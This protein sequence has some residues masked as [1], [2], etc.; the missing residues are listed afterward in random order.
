MGR[1]DGF[2]KILAEAGTDRVLGAHIVGQAAGE[3]IQE[4]AVLIEFGGSAEDLARTSHGH[5]TLSE[6]IREAASA[7]WFKPIHI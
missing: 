5:P 1:S 4:I 7:A 3:L 2:V 6:S